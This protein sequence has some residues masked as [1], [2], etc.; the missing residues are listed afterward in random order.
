MKIVAI[1]LLLLGILVAAV[2]S[3][4]PAS[5]VEDRIASRSQ[6]KLHLADASGTVWDGKGV[7][8]DGAGSW[9]LPVAWTISKAD[10]ARGV[11][12]VTL[13]PGAGPGSPTGTIEVVDG[14]VRV[15][16]LR[17]E[18]PAQ[19]LAGTLAL[20]PA[21]SLGGTVTVSANDLTWTDKAKSGGF[22]AHWRDA[23]IASGDNAAELGTVDFAGSPQDAR[24][25]G[26]LTN[27]GGDVRVDGNVTFAAGGGAT[28]DATLT[29]APNA[30]P[31]IASAIA[32][33]GTPDANGS[34]RIAWRGSVR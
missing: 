21:P 11:H 19:A 12:V 32:A 33:L 28:V 24:I 25:A 17:L 30:P 14:G 23:R 16:D 13:R 1:V 27:T 8:T 29:P 5:L 34:V 10:V 4:L 3:F 7:L 2:V 20:K 22:E 6:G 15:R 18:M 9:R 31:R 26:R